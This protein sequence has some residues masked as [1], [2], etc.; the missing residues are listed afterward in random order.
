MLSSARHILLCGLSGS[1]KSTAGPRLAQMLGRDFV[2][3]DKEIETRLGLPTSE[4][5][6][7]QGER[8]FR[9]AEQMCLAQCAE[10]APSVIALGGGAVASSEGLAQARALGTLVWL[11]VPAARAASRIKQ[12]NRP[13]LGHGEDAKVARLQGM[14]DKRVKHYA[15]ADVVVPVAESPHDTAKRIA[16]ALEDPQIA[17][18]VTSHRGTY[19]VR[20][21][22]FSDRGL[23]ELLRAHAP[24]SLVIV[25][26]EV[27]GERAQR[28][29]EHAGAQL[30]CVQAG[31]RLKRLDAIEALA[32]EL[33]ERQADRHTLIAAIGGGSLTDAVGFVAACYMRGVAWLSV[34]STLLGMVDSGLGG[35]VGVNAGHAKNLL[36]AFAPPRAVIA[37][38]SWLDALPERER[39]SGSA[40]MLKV[41]ATHDAALFAEL[42]AE[43]SL[44]LIA[45]AAAIKAGV[46]S[47]DEFEQGERKVLNFGHTFGHAFE[48]AAGLSELRHG[49]AIALGMI[50]ES[51]F[52]AARGQTNAEVLPALRGACARLALPQEWHAWA[53][54]A[55][56]F[57]QHD[58]KRAGAS[59]R[60]PV[61][62]Q[63]GRYTWTEATLGE[64]EAFLIENGLTKRGAQ[65]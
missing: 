40:E 46:V 30:V 22:R 23:G 55:A 17:S 5:F 48:S 60:L 4:I 44:P 62:P 49:E 24:R 14:L 39:R 34:P 6:A 53:D 9:A 35:K 42:S 13:L 37:D 57:L 19:A 28:V 20:T 38:L 65:V 27:L 56:A 45:R 10:L 18:F 64:M 32:L 16:Q 59:I 61:V 36:G 41:A 26:D 52:F 3:L 1:G 51:E 54:S 21:A 29:A 8:A 58:K 47:R 50:A 31:E 43:L 2:D 7:Q 11:A 12:G 15:Q 25:A 33:S 63:I